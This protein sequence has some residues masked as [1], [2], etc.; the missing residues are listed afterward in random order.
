M[1][2]VITSP[3][4]ALNCVP[5][6]CHHGLRVQATATHTAVDPAT[7]RAALY[8]DLRAVLQSARN[9][10]RVGLPTM[11]RYSV[12]EAGR[13]LAELAKLDEAQ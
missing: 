8:T 5:G 10:C 3:T 12:E 11:A 6:R 9:S 7:A 1:A 2:A 4:R 13:L